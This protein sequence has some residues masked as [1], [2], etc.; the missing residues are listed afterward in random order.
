MPGGSAVLVDPDRQRAR[1]PAAH[2]PV[3]TR[4]VPLSTGEAAARRRSSD[5]TALGGRDQLFAGGVK[6]QPFGE[7]VEQCRP[8]K[9]GFER[10][11]TAGNGRLAQPER[12]SGGT[13]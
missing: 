8:A 3:D 4:T 7:A 11:Q 9:T 1:N 10:G 5:S 6:A 13:H 12:T 2:S